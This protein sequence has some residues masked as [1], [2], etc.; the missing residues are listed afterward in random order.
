VYGTAGG[1]DGVAVWLPPGEAEITPERAARAGLDR[2]PEVLGAAAWERFRTLMDHMEQFHHQDVQPRHWYLPILGVDPAHQ[3]RGLGG[4][5]L[6]PILARAD[7]EGLPCYLETVEPR[8]VPFYQKH[9]FAVVT[10][11]VE[12]YSGVR[13]WTCRRDPR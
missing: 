1:T 8:N 5:L 7:T 12:P 10:E 11:G 4:R 3:G 6:A 13:F 9:G 2:A